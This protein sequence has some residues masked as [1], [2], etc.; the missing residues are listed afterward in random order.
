MGAMT[1]TIDGDR[2]HDRLD[3]L[4]QIGAIEG[5]LGCSRL[6]LTDEDK[7][8]RDL[9]MTWLHDLGLTTRVDGIGNVVATMPGWG[10][11]PPVMTGSHIDTVASGGRY[12]GNLGVLAGIDAIH[13]ENPFPC[14]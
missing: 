9:V 6:A 7:A 13:A 11:Q 8:G 10:D 14:P 4:A 3:A 5:T 1:L 2:L 12:D